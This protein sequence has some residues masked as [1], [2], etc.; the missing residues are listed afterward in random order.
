MLRDTPPEKFEAVLFQVESALKAEYSCLP[1][2][3]DTNC[4][5]AL[6]Q[7]KVAVKKR[8]GFAKSER[9]AS[10]PL[11]DGIIEAC[12]RVGLDH[13]DKVPGLDLRTYVAELEKLRRSVQRHSAQ[14][15]RGYYEFIRAYVP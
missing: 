2:L 9:V 14:G 3:T 5:F 10:D 11:I 8:F 12:V 13:V 15:P 4:A 6:D 1:A 7:A